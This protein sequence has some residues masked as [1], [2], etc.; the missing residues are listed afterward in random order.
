LQAESRFFC[1]IAPQNIGQPYLL[2]DRLLGNGKAIFQADDGDYGDELWITDGTTAGTTLLKD[3]NTGSNGSSPLHF[4]AL[5]NGKFLF[6]AN[7]GSHGEE[8][9]ITD[10]TTTGTTLLKDIDLSTTRGGSN[11]SGFTALGNGKA[12]FSADDGSHGKELWVTDGTA[13]G[14]KLVK[15]INSGFVI[16][17]GV[18]HPLSSSPSQFTALGNGKA[19]F[20]A[21]DGSNGEELWITDGTATGTM[22]LKDI[23]AGASGSSHFGATPLGNGQAIFSADDGINGEEL[24]I[25]DGTSVG[26]K[27]L[28]DINAEWRDS[29][30][31]DFTVL[32]NGK[33][34]FSADDGSLGRELWI[35]D[36]TAA[37][38]TLLL[39]IYAGGTGSSPS[40]FAAQGNGKLLFSAKGYGVGRELWVTDGTAIGTQLLK[41]ITSGVGSSSPNSFTNITF[42]ATINHAPTLTNFA[43]PV[44]SGNED[45]A[46]AVTLASL[47]AQGN[48]ADVGGSVTGFV[49]KAVSTGSL[50]IGA[51][52]ATA[53]A[54]AAGGNALIDATHIGYW[55][56]S[57]NA[58]GNLNAFSVV[59]R[60]NGGLQ[61]ATPVVAKVN[62]AP[63]RDDLIRNGSAG[64]DTLNGDA[65]DPGSYDTLNGLAGNDTLN[66]LAGNDTLNGGSGADQMT[67]GNGSD[68]YVVDDAADRVIESNAVAG[69]GGFDLVQSFIGY[70]LLDT[71]GAGSNGGNVENLR[72]MG[73]G[74]INA[75]GNGLNNVLY[76]NVGSNV[77][78]GG[79]GLDTVSY[80]FGVIGTT[81]VSVNLGNTSAQA[82][83]GSGNDKFVSIENLTGSPYNDSLTGNGLANV[84]SGGLGK[85]VLKGN[86]GNDIFDF[87]ALAEM[88]VTAATGDIILDFNSGDKIDL[89]TLD[90][91]SATVVNDA[92]TGLIGSAANFSAA[93]QLKFSGG[94][95]YGNIDADGAAEFA[96]VLNGVASFSLTDLL[97]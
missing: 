19:I 81:G 43:A 95:L 2:S 68:I 96:V 8:P 69:T 83:V 60:D 12:I 47:K 18:S 14:S 32:G 3:I 1:V 21:N 58:H 97:L 92:F 28:K 90:A 56:S 29:S 84:L 53:T 67:G 36:G 22:L 9:W 72:L 51:S 38:T 49:V 80:Q 82:T 75:T 41:D 87:N 91:N 5:G 64:N 46:I 10:G 26:T 23:S 71:D 39:D 86:G 15:D 57:A 25:T 93:G 73:S 85:D 27:M 11:S 16:R 78:N 54:W 52:L 4:S 20:S 74:S 59:A 62:V 44:A 7:D 89:S 61:S 33:A 31:Y 37:G 65:I 66:G 40:G 79:A 76:A 13:I 42:N 63:V 70:S 24:W 34:I 45:S 30:P 48:E 94:V 88:G 77:L 55:T 35:T 6:S 17:L 50:K